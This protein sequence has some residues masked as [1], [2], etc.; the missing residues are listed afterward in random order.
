MEGKHSEAIREGVQDY[1]L[2]CLLRDKVQS[3]RPA[4]GDSA[5]LTQAEKLLGD[6]VAEVL[7]TVKADNLEW[8]SAKDRSRMDALRIQLMDAL[9]RMP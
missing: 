1:E 7:Q 3:V 8:Q 9:E 6:G 2:L 5:W 4:K